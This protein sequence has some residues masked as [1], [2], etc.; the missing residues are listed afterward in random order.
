MT[1][2]LTDVGMERMTVEQALNHARLAKV[3]DRGEVPAI[4]AMVVLADA[5]LELRQENERLKK[6]CEEQDL[7]IKKNY[8]IEDD[9]AK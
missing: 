3:I 1:D 6:R 4:S 5:L 7:Y 9:H 8:M 2:Q